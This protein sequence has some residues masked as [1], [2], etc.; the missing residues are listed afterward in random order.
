MKGSLPIPGWATVLFACLLLIV[1]GSL[2]AVT[3]L[4]LC[5]E[6]FYGVPA[7]VLS[8]TGD[9]R[10]PVIES[11]GFNDNLRGIDRHMYWMAPMGMVVQA[12]VFKVFGF[13]LLVQREL[14]VFCALAALLFW[15]LA[16][17]RLVAN[18]VAALAALVLSAD[19]V[20][21][22]LASLGRSDMISL[23]FAMAALA[24]YLH[25]RERSL[26]LALAVANTA[27]ALSGMVHPNGGIAAVVSLAVLTMYLDRRRL[28]WSHLFVVAVCYIVPGSGWGLYIAKDPDL[29]AAQFLGN[30]ASRLDGPLA[31]GGLV[32]G[33]TT[34]YLSA[35]GL[36]NAHGVKLVR[37][38]LPMSYLSAV[39]FCAVSRTLRRQSRV[40]LLMFAAVSLSLVFLEG[41]K[42]GWYLVNL[43]PLFAALLAIAANRL[44]ESGNILA[45]MVTA[46]QAF[47]VLLGVTG[48][49]YSASNRNLQRLYEPT[50]AF[51]NARVGPQDLV[52][53]RSEFYFGLQCRTCL[54]DDK[55]LGARSGRR[56]NYIVIDSDHEAYLARM[57]ATRPAIYRD[58]EQRMSMEYR[59]VFRNSNYRVLQRFL[60][61]TPS[62]K[63]AL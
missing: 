32:Q 33:E 58:L 7:H 51:L 43:S 56:A 60:A 52:F 57:R 42:Q 13:G 26:G 59:E 5:D 47:V 46:A 39:L 24:G 36:E 48:L 41:A 4:P 8:V 14:S 45:R 40:L 55:H 35:W 1:L 16:L 3:R 31:L 15:Y 9:L 63:E 23:F 34:R 10:N 21:L 49:V 50:V 44:W 37:Y 12:G 38:L 20:F 28:R 6:G 17:R 22:N 11:T 27:C 61:K 62:R 30:V 53:A 25:W 18:R 2:L 29:F 54:R 19:F